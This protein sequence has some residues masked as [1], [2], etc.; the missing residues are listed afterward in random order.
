[1]TTVLSGVPIANDNRNRHN[2]APFRG[3]VLF[4]KHHCQETLIALI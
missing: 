2:T 1:M 4:V 3:I